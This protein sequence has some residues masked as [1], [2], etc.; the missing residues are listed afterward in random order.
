[1]FSKTKARLG[2]RVRFILSGSAPLDPKLGEFL[3]ICFCCSIIEGYGLTEN[4]A[5]ASISLLEDTQFGHIG[6]PLP[7]LEIKLV[8]VPEMSYSSKNKPQTGEVMLRG[9]SVFKGYFKDV[10]KTKEA[11]EADGWFHTGDVGRW[12]ENGTLSI[13]DRKKNIFKLAQGEYVAVEYLEGVFKRSKY[14]A[15]IWVYGSSFQRYLIAFVHPDQET[16][17]LWAKE[18]GLQGDLKAWCNNSKVNKLILGDL[19]RVAKEGKLHGFEF[20]KAVTLAP[21][22]FTVEKDLMTPT[23]KLRRANLVKYYKKEIDE[24]YEKIKD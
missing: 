4:A 7:H 22:P 1:L 5:G 14:V 24:M 10:E 2:G 13:I 15:Q 9:G 6:P 21:E 11:L 12:N 8:D 18:Q 19:E 20:I 16:V 17:G 3:K 23:F